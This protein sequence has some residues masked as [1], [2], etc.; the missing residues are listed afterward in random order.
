M[1]WPELMAF[2]F[3]GWSTVCHEGRFWMRDEMLRCVW[4]RVDIDFTAS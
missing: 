2:A 3:C 4:T 1:T